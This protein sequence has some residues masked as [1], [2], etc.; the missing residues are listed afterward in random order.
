MNAKIHKIKQYGAGKLLYMTFYRIIRYVL[1]RQEELVCIRRQSKKILELKEREIP[2]IPIDKYLKYCNLSEDKLAVAADEYEGYV[3]LFGSKFSFNYK[4]DW[5]RD[6]ITG[7]YWDRNTIWYKCVGRNASCD[8]VKYVLELNKFGHLVDFAI[9]YKIGGDEKYVLRIYEELLGWLSCVPL[10]KS[11]AN[12]IVM[13]WAFRAIN[14][15]HMSFLC[16][17]SKIYRSKVH[18]LICNILSNQARFMYKFCTSRWFKSENNNNHDI[19][20]LVGIYAVWLWLEKFTDI[21]VSTKRKQTILDYLK[22]VLEITIDKSGVY[23]EHS[24]SYSRLVAEFLIF[25]EIIDNI[26]NDKHYLTKWFYDAQYTQRLIGYIKSLE[27]YGSYPNFGDNDSAQL[28][29]P[30][31]HKFC[32][33]EHIINYCNVD[34]CLAQANDCQFIYKSEDNN[35][36]T[37]IRYGQFAIYREGAFVHSHCDLLSPIISLR[38]EEVVIDKGC[39]YY[40]K[41]IEYRRLYTQNNSHNGISITGYD[42]AVLMSSGY[43][44]YPLCKLIR[45]EKSSNSYAMSGELVYGP[46]KNTR[47][48]SYSND[49]IIIDDYVNINNDSTMMGSIQY[50]IAPQFTIEERNGHLEL[51]S[52]KTGNA[53]TIA[54]LGVDKIEIQESDYYV[55]YANARKTKKIVGYFSVCKDIKITTKIQF[56]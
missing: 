42:M 1:C 16:G 56:K 23:L 6:P 19:G 51:I 32:G 38:G 9:A 4:T 24:A 10:E 46:I 25:F 28:L 37:F 26:F 15:M 48:F 5:L 21:K 40:N 17:D 13:D 44:N 34:S 7:S 27:Y 35:T 49:S 43:S 30:F 31:N 53:Y 12:W 11:V 33:I 18:P 39:E 50:Y 2:Q 8:D 29:R 45:K 55:G 41:G 20:E 22:H 47:D 52:Q 14:L 3:N 36:F 54:L